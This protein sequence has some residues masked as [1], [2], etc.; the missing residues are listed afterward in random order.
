MSKPSENNNTD[1]WYTYTDSTPKPPST[2]TPTDKTILEDAHEIATNNPQL[3]KQPQEAK[4]PNYRSSFLWE[5]K[6][7]GRISPMGGNL[8]GYSREFSQ[9]IHSQHDS[10]KLQDVSHGS[11]SQLKTYH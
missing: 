2:N 6:S 7:H 8:H 3:I 9:L 1:L 4:R 11:F 5:C 10:V